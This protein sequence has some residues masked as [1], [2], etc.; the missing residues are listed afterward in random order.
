MYPVNDVFAWL[1]ESF[2]ISLMPASFT[3]PLLRSTVHGLLSVYTDVGSSWI[4]F[5][6]PPAPPRPPLL[7]CSSR[8][9]VSGLSIHSSGGSSW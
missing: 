1:L 9:K 5:V 6:S 7:A 2:A 3:S 8:L 4:F